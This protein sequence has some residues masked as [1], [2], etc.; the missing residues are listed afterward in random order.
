ML[1]PKNR[2]SHTAGDILRLLRQPEGALREFEATFA[3]AMGAPEGIAFPYCRVAMRTVLETVQPLGERILLPAYSCSVVAHAVTL[4]GYQPR[5]VDIDAS[6][7]VPISAY[8][9]RWDTRTAAVIPTHMFGTPTHTAALEQFVT[10]PTLFIEDSALGLHPAFRPTN[11]LIRSVTVYSFGSN[12]PLS[13]IRGGM[14]VTHDTALAAQIR[15]ARDRRLRASGGSEYIKNLLELLALD[16]L[17]HPIPYAFLDRFRHSRILAS[18]LDTRSIDVAAFPSNAGIQLSDGIGAVGLAQLRQ[19]HVFIERRRAFAVR[20]R[21][22]LRNVSDLQVVS[23]PSTSHASHVLVRVPDRDRRKFR[24]RLHTAG[25]EVGRTFDYALPD[26]RP[27]HAF[28]DQP[29]REAR[30]AAA[31]GF[32]LPNYPALSDA[33]YARI[34]EA[35]RRVATI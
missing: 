31:E 19:R 1:I 26:L 3:A 30:A 6:Y 23:L 14:I 29:F 25:V 16:F 11:P 13:T 5:F 9:E 17:F 33:H 34:I 22:A 8:G 20:Y 32:N 7:D 15:V 18:H 35:V 12:K 4:A 2:P 21:E 24:E 10:R 28:D 27:Y